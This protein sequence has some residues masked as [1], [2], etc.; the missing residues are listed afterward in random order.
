[1]KYAGSKEQQDAEEYR[2]GVKQHEVHARINEWKKYE[3]ANHCQQIKLKSLQSAKAFDPKAEGPN[4][5]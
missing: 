4:G 2:V 1:M 3:P 5:T